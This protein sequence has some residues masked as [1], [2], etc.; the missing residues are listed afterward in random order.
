[1]EKSDNKQES[2]EEKKTQKPAT[3]SQS[4]KETNKPICGIVMP[5]G[6][7]DG[8]G[9]AHWREVLGILTDAIE[10][11]GFETSLVSDEPDSGI[12]HKRIIQNLYSNDL[13]VV[14]VS[15]KNPNVMFELG[16]RLAFDKPTIIVKDDKTGYS[17]DTSVIEHL[18]YPRDL[19][20]GL[21]GDFMTALT[22]KVKATYKA[23]QKSGYSTFLQHF[24]RFKIA[25]IEEMEISGQEFILEKLDG[26]TNE[27]KSL[28]VNS[29]QKIHENHISGYSKIRVRG[30]TYIIRKNR[31]DRV[32]KFVH[33][34]GPETG[35]S[36]NSDKIAFQESV[37]S[38]AMDSGLT[39]ETS[40]AIAEYLINENYPI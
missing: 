9:E 4:T 28:R 21:I 38:K 12:I 37:K 3:K 25:N 10:A 31:F 13:V 7:I 23:S 15:A 8:L 30:K 16:M 39:L 36:S 17:F 35:F 26:L 27:V 11:A 29:H 32:S 20:F 33:E 5:I 6:A 24:G 19:R 18:G 22:A 40:D 2:P 14:D 1:M 34:F